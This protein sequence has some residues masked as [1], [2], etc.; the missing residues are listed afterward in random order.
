MS[1]DDDRAELQVDGG[2]FYHLS[3][4]GDEALFESRDDAVDHLRDHK[5]EIDTD[6]PAVTLAVV[7]T[8]EE[9]AIESVPWQTIALQLL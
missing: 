8:G 1:S 2:E 9:W 7:E 6:D 5:D 3:I 4:N